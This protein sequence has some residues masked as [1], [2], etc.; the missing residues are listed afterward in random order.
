MNEILPKIKK[1]IINDKHIT[2]KLRRLINKLS[3]EN[4]LQKDEYKFIL[5]NITY[6][7]TE[8]LFDKSYQAKQP[9]YQNRV[10]LRGLLEISNYCKMGCKYC[11]INYKVD[12]IERYRLNKDEILASCETGYFLGYRTFVLQGG[13]DSYFTD[14]R[15]ADLLQT[16]KNK[17][18]DIR[19]TLSLGER[20]Y[21]SYKTLREA[22]AD[23]Y[24]LR[25]ETAS[26]RLYN[27]LHAD[28]MK[29]EN[30]QKCLYNLKEL[31]YQ[32]GAGFMVG[33]PTQTNSDLVED[34]VFLKELNPEMV[35]IGPYLCHSDTELKGNDSGTLIESLIMVSLVRLVLPKALLPATTALGTLDNLGRENALKV[36][37]NVMMPNISPT[38]N[39]E[40]YEIYQNKICTGDT[41][42]QCRGCIENRIKAFGHEIDLGVGDNVDFERIVKS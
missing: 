40:L 23:R 42:V 29:F 17:F 11:G 37:A 38:E 1:N 5:D 39:R 14:E 7:D 16:M 41:S 27:H 10:Y 15:L 26:K 3:V 35:G 9:H 20:S 25:H 34:L 32:V 8:Y 36:G 33:S 22:G 21:E 24:L 31:G 28:F 4:E 30:R 13:E 6:E 12:T 18:K 2:A 19:I